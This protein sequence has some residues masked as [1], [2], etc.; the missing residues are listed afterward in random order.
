MTVTTIYVHDGCQDNE[1]KYL[2][3]L[4]IVTHFLIHTL[5]PP[6]AQIQGASSPVQLNCIWWHFIF[7]GPQYGTCFTH[8]A[9]TILR[10]LL[11]VLKILAPLL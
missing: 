9:L 4:A 8:L 7:V 3:S 11:E 5:K 1:A 10:S 6:S 2:I